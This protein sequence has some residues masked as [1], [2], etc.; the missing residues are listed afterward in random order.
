MGHAFPQPLWKRFGEH[1]GEEAED[2]ESEGKR[3]K[4]RRKRRR[5]RRGAGDFSGVSSVTL[6][7]S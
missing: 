4:R 7:A 6:G 3:K 5:R 1:V 2:E